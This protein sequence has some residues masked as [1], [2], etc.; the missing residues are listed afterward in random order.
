MASAGRLRPFAPDCLRQIVLAD[1]PALLA[2]E[3]T[4][5]L[6]ALLRQDLRAAPRL[7]RGPADPLYIV[8][9]S[10]TT[11]VPKGVILKSEGVAQSLRSIVLFNLV[12]PR[13]LA[14]FARCRSTIRCPSFICTAR[15]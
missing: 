9:T 13:D 5:G 14:S 7:E 4:H 8:H 11:G 1:S 6:T 3:R 15:C 10:G 12:S 2:G